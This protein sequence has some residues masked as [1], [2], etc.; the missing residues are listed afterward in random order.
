MFMTFNI[1]SKWYWIIFCVP[2]LIL[3]SVDIQQQHNFIKNQIKKMKLRRVKSLTS[4]GSDERSFPFP[5]YSSVVSDE[6]LA[7][8]NH[9]DFEQLNESNT[10]LPYNMEEQMCEIS[11]LEFDFDC[12]I[13]SVNL[14]PHSSSHLISR[15]LSG[16]ARLRTSLIRL[17]E[18][19][20][21]LIVDAFNAN[22]HGPIVNEETIASYH[23]IELNDAADMSIRFE[24]NLSQE[25]I[26]IN[27]ENKAALKKVNIFFYSF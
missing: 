5:D 25:Q 22:R 21:Q 23:I 17:G 4:L 24:N 3:T 7:W 10:W 18:K 6:D 27:P 1:G 14:T 11:F 15:P 26:N 16:L 9:K 20:M 19:L 13:S 12:S 8:D 2:Y